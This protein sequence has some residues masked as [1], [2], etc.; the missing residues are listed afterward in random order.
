MKKN[1]RQPYKKNSRMVNT[2]RQMIKNPNIELDDTTDNNMMNLESSDIP[3]EIKSENI[4]IEKKGFMLEFTDWIKKN[5]IGT[6]LIAII[7]LLLQRG[8]DAKINITEINVKLGHIEEIVTKLDDSYA[9]KEEVRIE[10][11]NIKSLIN[12]NGYKDLNDIKR[13]VNEL[14]NK[15]NKN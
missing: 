9:R 6:I 15:L 11:D 2:Y 3:S 7:A 4:L 13:K 10:I 8:I 14:E 1:H 5:Y 12:A